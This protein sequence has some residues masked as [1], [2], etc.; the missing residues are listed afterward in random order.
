MQAYHN[1]SDGFGLSCDELEEVLVEIASELQMSLQAV[2]LL[3]KELF[4]CLDT[5]QNG[6]IDGIE[7]LAVLAVCSGLS[8]DET[9]EFGLSLCDFNNCASLSF[10]ELVL[11]LKAAATG[12]CKICRPAADDPRQAIVLP[13]EAK[14]ENIASQIYSH[15]GAVLPVPRA[16]A[17]HSPLPGT[18]ATGSGYSVAID[19]RSIKDIAEK[20]LNVPEVCSWIEY[21]G[22]CDD[23]PAA[24]PRTLPSGLDPYAGRLLR[25]EEEYAVVNWSLLPQVMVTV[26]QQASQQWKSQAALLAPVAYSNSTFSADLPNAHL[27]VDWIYGFESNL[28]NNNAL[29]TRTSSIIYTAGKYAIVY[30]TQTHKQKVLSQ[31]TEQILAITVAP[32]M[33]TVASSEDG[34]HAKV[35]VWSAETMSVLFAM[36]GMHHDGVSQLAFNSS[37]KILLAVDRAPIK[38][39]VAVRWEDGH[40]LFKDTIK[41]SV[42]VGCSVLV[43]DTFVI[44]LDAE[45]IFWK[46]YPEGYLQRKGVY[47]KNKAPEPLTCLL[48]AANPDQ[49]YGGSAGGKIIQIANINTIREV[50]AHTGRINVLALCKDGFLSAGDDSK[51]RSWTAS[52]E[53]RFIFDVSRFGLTP[54]IHA[55]AVSYDNTSILFGTRGGDMFEISSVDGADLRGGPIVKAHASASLAHIDIHPSK[56]E[57]ASVGADRTLR[58]MDMKTKTVLKVAVLKVNARCLA[59]NPLGDVLAIGTE[60]ALEDGAMCLIV[61]EEHL[62]ILHS[63]RDSKSAVVAIKFSPEGETLALGLS[64]GSVLLYSVHDDYE[65][66]AKCIRH[67]TPVFQMDFSIEGE[68]IRTNSANGDL[69]FFNVDDGSLQSNIASMRDVLW[70][71]QSCQF[72]WHTK[73]MHAL[74]H[75]AESIASCNV[76]F[77]SKLDTVDENEGSEYNTKQIDIIASGSTLG[78]VRLQR[79]PLILDSTESVRYAAHVGPVMAA[80]FSFDNNFLLTAGSQDRVIIQFAVHKDAVQN[81]KVTQV[82]EPAAAA[83]P[84]GDNASVGNTSQTSQLSKG[85]EKEE[86]PAAAADEIAFELLQGAEIAGA[87]TIKQAPLP[88]SLLYDQSHAVTHPR[89]QWMDNALLPSSQAN[90]LPPPVVSLHSTLPEVSVHLQYLHGYETKACRNNLHYTANSKEIVYTAGSYGLV[91]NTETKAQKIFKL[92]VNKISAFTGSRDGAYFATGDLGNPYS[93]VYVWNATCNILQVIGERQLYS[94]CAL[95]F[96]RSNTYLAVVSNDR[97]HTVSVYDWKKNILLGKFSTSLTKIIAISFISNGAQGVQGN[98]IEDLSLVVLGN[99]FIKFYYHILTRFTHSLNAN[100]SGIGNLQL[101]LVAEQLG[102][103][104][105]IGCGDGSLY[106]FQR[107]NLTQ[108]VAAHINGVYAMDVSSTKALLITGGGD[109]IVRLWNEKLECVQEYTMSAVSKCHNNLIRAVSLS[110][111]NTTLLVGLQGAEVIEMSVKDAAVNENV[112]IKGHTTQLLALAAHPRTGQFATAG[113]DAVLRIYDSRKRSHNKSLK[114]ET[115]CRALAYSPD[116]THLAIGYGCNKRVKRKLHIKEGAFVII[117]VE[118]MRVVYEHKDSNMPLRSLVYSGDGKHLCIGS[119]DSKVYIYNVP[120]GYALKHNLVS[121]GA[122]VTSLDVSMSNHFLISQDSGQIIHHTVMLTGQ[123]VPSLDDIRDEKWA[124]NIIPQAWYGRAHWLL[125]RTDTFPTCSARSAGNNLFSSG[126]GSGELFLTAYPAYEMTG[127]WALPGHCGSVGKV[128]FLAGDS[129]LVSIGAEDCL[130]AQYRCTPV[131]GVV[132]GPAKLITMDS[133]LMSRAVFNSSNPTASASLLPEDHSGEL[134]V[135]QFTVDQEVGEDR[136]LPWHALITAPSKELPKRINQRALH[137]S[138]AY[139]HGSQRVGL[140]PCVFYNAQGNVI[141]VIGNRA[142]IFHT[143]TCKQYYYSMKNEISAIAM[144]PD[145]CLCV[146]ADRAV[147]VSLHFWDALTGDGIA[148]LTNVSTHG[149]RCLS[150]SKSARYLA[151]AGLDAWHSINI[152]YSPSGAWHDAMYLSSS[153]C[154]F[155][156]INCLVFAED[157]EY[158][159]QAAGEDGL[160]HNYRLLNGSLA[161]QKVLLDDLQ[162]KEIISSLCWQIFNTVL[163]LSVDVMLYGCH[164]GFLYA[165]SFETAL[166]QKISAHSGPIYA[167][168]PVTLRQYGSALLSSGH[169]HCVRLWSNSLQLLACFELNKL[170]HSAAIAA[171]MVFNEVKESLLLYLLSGEVVE[172]SLYGQAVQTLAEAHRCNALHG[173]AVHPSNPALF[174]T[175]GD[176]GFLRIWHAGYHYCLT[177]KYIRFG[178]R[179]VAYSADASLL[180]VGI[181]LPG[182]QQSSPKDGTVMVLDA[183]SCELI[184]EERKG[185]GPITDIQRTPQDDKL[186]VASMDGKVYIISLAT[187]GTLHI[188]DLDSRRPALRVDVSADLMLV[189]IAY[190]SQRMIYYNLLTAAADA[191]PG[192]AKDAKWFSASVPYSWTTQAAHKLKDKDKVDDYTVTATALS[193]SAKLLAVGYACGAIKVLAYPCIEEEA[194]RTAEV[195]LRVP[196]Y[197]ARLAFTCDDSQLIAIDANGG[198]ITQ[199]QIDLHNSGASQ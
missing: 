166:L 63:F 33:Q 189:R 113:D 190:T 99:R 27:T 142:V 93:N 35:L 66:I 121:H 129:G 151:S 198:S 111:D 20:L 23:R 56:F 76:P 50:T 188:V 42:C 145:R 119:E 136:T 68:W 191:N 162:G 112:A 72:A 137:T 45:L 29:Y 184:R 67:T 26:G 46:K 62:N 160:L 103:Q 59:Y 159:V 90:A 54:S 71:S 43:K 89:L 177:S 146:T 138:V 128:R 13:S 169:D 4:V 110:L 174:A 65:L 154:S 69:F 83:A 32:D 109:G 55:L 85:K 36:Q 34:A 41:G 49:L 15:L 127:L 180:I 192:N 25:K 149:I 21:Y 187:L 17:N 173:L 167:L 114:L 105:V 48:R 172:M 11:A 132:K 22:N 51:I 131:G 116:G 81:E 168:L 175:A 157:R 107:N 73:G 82:L 97:Y 19:R 170:V 57:Y 197:A 12:L 64:D 108:M 47:L 147:R 165:I 185:K 104:A 182:T 155:A 183:V 75:Q 84:A 44:S 24:D 100:F 163:N 94:V 124:S 194:A 74:E 150:F 7:L 37:G 179:A 156:S 178:S 134:F 102:G 133:T 125:Q 2:R 196:S 120:D 60:N 115:G 152:Y 91:Y 86:V 53:A 95:A 161:S 139:V 186:A 118:N 148:C 130:I 78:Q 171:S 79:Y 135:N 77:L 61:N 14:L 123:E 31:H 126:N 96:S 30:S 141:H 158:A 101:F 3:A 195:V 18:N 106:M 193:A 9:I 92:H 153:I 87:C 143:S 8:K 164:E 144:S 28:C 39:I 181:G 40:V 176:D 1:I 52:L 122:M 16:D 199:I 70:A 98:E 6:L 140:H 88:V 10:D 5:D 58:V 80:K 117:S 38:T